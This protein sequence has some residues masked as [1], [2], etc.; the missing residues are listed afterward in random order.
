MDG[1]VDLRAG[2]DVAVF[3]RLQ[4]SRGPGPSFTQH[5]H[6]SELGLLILNATFHASAL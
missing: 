3:V 1:W 2:T 4:L 6:F 5:L